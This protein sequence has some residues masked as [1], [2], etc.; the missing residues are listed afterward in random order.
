MDA[1]RGYF[2][3]HAAFVVRA[4]EAG[5]DAQGGI[6]PAGEIIGCFYVKPNYPGRCAH[7]CNGR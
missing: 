4:L 5:K 2:L 7:V 3:S 1:Y 6:S